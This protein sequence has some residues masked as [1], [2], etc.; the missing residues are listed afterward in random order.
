MECRFV[1]INC[2]VKAFCIESPDIQPY[3]TYSHSMLWAK[4]LSMSPAAQTSVPSIAGILQPTLFING[5][6]N[7][8]KNQ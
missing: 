3:V 5:P 8:P 6:V 2:F 1:D 7:M 4:I